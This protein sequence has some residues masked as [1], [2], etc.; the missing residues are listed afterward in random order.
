M[1]ILQNPNLRKALDFFRPLP[2][3]TPCLGL[4]LGRD[5]LTALETVGADE[6]ARVLS[7]Q[8]FPLPAP[9]FT[10]PPSPEALTALSSV[11]AG[12]FREK[13]DHYYTLQVSLP[14]P[15]AQWEVFELEQ[16]PAAGNATDEFLRWR[17]Q[18]DAQEK[19][20]RRFRSQK[21]GVESGRQLLLGVGLDTAWLEAIEGALERSGARVSLLDV[22]FHHRF[23]LLCKIYGPAGPGALLTLEKDYWSLAVWDGQVRPRLLRSK[24]WEHNAGPSS[25]TL[26]ALAWEAERTIRSYVYSTPGR[27]VERLFLMAPEPWMEKALEVLFDHTGGKAEALSFDGLFSPE[28]PAHPSLFPSTGATAVRQ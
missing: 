27:S 13:E 22:A 19:T 6:K 11:L 24:W 26:E 7:H 9:L 28:G 20:S 25:P 1:G 8:F 23:N 15:A 4:T 18:S 2:G 21:L 17:F 16:V 14:D 10:A 5:G 12:L 3:E